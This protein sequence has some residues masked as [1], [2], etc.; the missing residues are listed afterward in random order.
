MQS[1][2]RVLRRMLYAIL[3]VTVLIG[4]VIFTRENYGWLFSKTVKGEVI[5]NERVTNPTAIMGSRAT[6]EML[7]SYTV[8]IRD[9]SGQMVTAS[10]ED[11]QWAVVSP[12]FCVVAKF[13]PYPFW[14]LD[15]GGTYGNARL[16]RIYD[17]PGK[18][19]T[20]AG[21]APIGTPAPA[22]TP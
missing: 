19:P 20:E 14:E 4:V 9:E 8:L 21:R 2:S 6:P 12:G 17:C 7:H 3:A 18:G 15:K 11:R 16:E 22:S 5:R 13:Y 10:S 1:F